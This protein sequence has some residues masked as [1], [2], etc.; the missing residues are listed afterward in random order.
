V[1]RQTK[2]VHGLPFEPFLS[3][4]NRHEF[5]PYNQLRDDVTRWYQQYLTPERWRMGVFTVDGLYR[6]FQELRFS[7]PIVVL[8]GQGCPELASLPIATVNVIATSDHGRNWCHDHSHGERGIWHD[9]SARVRACQMSGW[10]RRHSNVLPTLSKVNAQR[11]LWHKRYDR[12]LDGVLCNQCIDDKDD[13][14]AE[15]KGLDWLPD[16]CSACRTVRYIFEQ[17]VTYREWQEP[18]LYADD[19]PHTMWAWNPLFKK[20]ASLIQ[21]VFSIFHKQCHG[22]FT[23]EVLKAWIR[24]WNM[25]VTSMV[26]RVWYS[27]HPVTLEPSPSSP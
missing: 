18:L 22:L 17:T 14:F 4:H 13:A 15:G 20:Q 26:I 9:C 3:G 11:V 16:N 2:T 25:Y 5:H 21:T 23:R 24:M 1:D 27:S 19:E 7:Y 12:L 8:E 6:M 10:L